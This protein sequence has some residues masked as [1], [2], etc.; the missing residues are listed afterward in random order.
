MPRAR[1][2]TVLLAVLL[3]IGVAV[4]I[5]W[6]EAVGAA[7]Y[8]RAQAARLLVIVAATAALTTLNLFLRWLRWSFLV[9]RAGIRLPTRESVR[10]YFATLPAI[11]TPFYVGELIRGFLLNARIPGAR[12]LLTWVWAIERVTDA[13]VLLVLLLV[14]RGQ[15][16]W[17]LATLVLWIVAVVIVARANARNPVG[18]QLRRPPVILVVF[19]SSLAA[20]LLPMGTLWGALAA[21]DSS[22]APAAAADAMAT[23]TQLGGIFGVPLG[24]GVTGSATIVLLERY[25]VAPEVAAT[26][27]AAFRAGTSWYAV[28]LGLVTLVLHRRKL[29]AF[30]GPAFAA[31]HFSAI[32][33]GYQD[34]IPAHIRDRLL[35]RKIEFMERRLAERAGRGARGLDVGCGHGWYAC[36]LTS[37]GYDLDAVDSASGQIEQALSLAA[38]RGCGARFQTADAEHLPWPDGTF[39]FVYSINVIHHVTPIEK[40]RRVLAE[41]VRVLKPGGQFF[42]QEIN[43]ENPLFR[44]YMSYFFPLLCD[45]DEGTE[46]WIRPSRLP[47]VAGARWARDVDYFTFLPD[48]T[49]RPVLDALAGLE[50]RLERSPIRTWSAHYI[51]RLEKL[52]G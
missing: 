28:G 24:T 14:A 49:P 38:A 7:E 35:D 36:E 20:W 40:R 41:I 9:R 22:V 5:L 23:G 48:F 33:V 10:L 29:V 18:V 30:L 43:T 16:T 2:F 15:R 46:E 45:I 11:A 12:A 6:L 39:D 4:T 19:T 21:L 32:A 31:D 51:A 44:F 37:R 26:A 8:L 42:L 25:G 13:A 50:A 17:A 47:D 3:A 52:R 1:L 34:Q 27:V